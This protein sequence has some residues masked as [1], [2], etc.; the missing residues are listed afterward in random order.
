M[1][2][3]NAAAAAAATIIIIII[4][5]NNNSGWSLKHVLS[6]VGHFQAFL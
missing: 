3:I 6:W 4:I 1:L 2:H 5:Y